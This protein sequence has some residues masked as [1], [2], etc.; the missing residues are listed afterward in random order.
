M[1]FTQL[2]TIKAILNTLSNFTKGFPHALVVYNLPA[3]QECGFDPWAGKIPWRK[4]WQL[5]LLFFLGNPMDRVW[6]AIVHG[7]TKSQTRLSD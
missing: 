3:T 1:R 2:S 4:K 6:W 5:T 7:V